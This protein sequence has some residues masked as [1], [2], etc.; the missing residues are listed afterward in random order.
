MVAMNPINNN[1]SFN[2]T[3]ASTTKC[4]NDNPSSKALAGGESLNMT[5]LLSKSP[6]LLNSIDMTSNSVIGN[7]D[8][9]LSTSV[10]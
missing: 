6:Q 7:Q 2:F 5:Q 9:L 1:Q 4:T 10:A 8:N 3:L